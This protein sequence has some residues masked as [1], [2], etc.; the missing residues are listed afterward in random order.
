L[1]SLSIRMNGCCRREYIAAA[2]RRK[3]A[4][5]ATRRG[6]SAPCQRGR[7]A[8]PGAIPW[9]S[10]ERWW[11]A[12]ACGR[13]VEAQPRQA[14]C[15]RGIDGACLLAEGDEWRRLLGQRESMGREC[16]EAAV[17]ERVIVRR[18]VTCGRSRPGPA[19]YVVV[20]V[21]RGRASRRGRQARVLGGRLALR[22]GRLLEHVRRRQMQAR[23]RRTECQSED[24]DESQ[25]SPRAKVATGRTHRLTVIEP[26]VNLAVNVSRRLRGE[27]SLD[28]GPPASRPRTA[29]L[30]YCRRCSYRA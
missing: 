13:P 1:G 21:G 23:D 9:R 8:D 17:L 5:E 6:R 12:R 10:A 3:R 18:R 30:R 19:C 26:H 14:C 29:G 2:A 4:R 16:T 25:P 7:L 24:R 28:V 22:V 27:S 20:V 15:Y 11:S